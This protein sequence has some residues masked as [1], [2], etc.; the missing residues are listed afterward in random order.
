MPI[1][2]HGLGLPEEGALVAG[3]LGLTEQVA[4]AMSATLTGSGTLTATLTTTTTNTPPADPQTG[5]P[6]NWRPKKKPAVTV[7]LSARLGGRSTFAA[8][9]DVAVHMDDLDFEQLLVL[10][11]V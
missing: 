10:E 3:G 9:L 8:D 6:G 1:V 2:A 5:R 4:G 7:E 11:L